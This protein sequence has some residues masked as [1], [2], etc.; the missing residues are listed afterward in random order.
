MK[1]RL[2]LCPALLLLSLQA[3]AQ[4][5]PPSL[6]K[7]KVRTVTVPISI[8]TKKE[9]KDRRAEEYVQVETITVKE[10]NEQQQIL[11]IRSVEETPL[12]I[13]I[14]IQDDLSSGFNNQLKDVRD[15]I[16][17]LPRGT[18]VMTA[19]LRA[20]TPQITQKW[21]ED[22]ELAAKSLRV[23][24]SSIS[25]APS[26][27]Y[28]GVEQIL[29]RFDAIPAG[30]RAVLLFS[31]GLDTSGGL[32]LASIA[33]SFDLEQAIVKAQKRSVAVYSFDW[34]TER[35]NGNNTLGFAAQGA[36]QKLSNETG[37]RA[38]GNGISELP[39]F[40]P[41]FSDLEMT[42]SRQFALSYLSTHMKKGYHS[43]VITSSNPDVKIEHPA[44]Y[45]YR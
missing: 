8:L 10:D 18:R 13:A 40:G 35:T 5:D 33:Q 15:F 31:D 23:V 9:L 32:N 24:S 1:A 30:R 29:S 19:Y 4:S 36:L 28:D 37:G 43:L 7:Q 44:G 26:S 41:Y 42:L 17:T 34:P 39:G 22:L 25:I 11:S 12:S 45:Y 3:I 27:P 16:R 21:T 38:F 20:G 14:L 2:L 6:P